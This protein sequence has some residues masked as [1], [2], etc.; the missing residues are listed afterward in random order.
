MDILYHTKVCWLSRRNVQSRFAALMDYIIAFLGQKVKHI[1][2]L[3][4]KQCS[5]DLGLLTDVSSHLNALN[6]ILEGTDNLILDIV[7][8]FFAGAPVHIAA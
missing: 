2:E 6:T 5:W 3:E 8:T 7:S 4:D 1:P